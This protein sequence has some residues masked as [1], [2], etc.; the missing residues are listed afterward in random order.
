MRVRLEIDRNAATD[1]IPIQSPK[2]AKPSA[3]K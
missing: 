2:A 3:K 1:P